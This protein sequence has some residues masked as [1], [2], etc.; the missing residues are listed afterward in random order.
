MKSIK[1]QYKIFVLIIAACLIIFTLSNLLIKKDPRVIVNLGDSI[2]GNI[3][4]AT[5]ISAIIANKTKATVY[6]G[7][8]GGCQMRQRSN[9][10]WDCFSMY[11]I[12]DA[13]S[14]GDW[15]E[16]EHIASSGVSGMP[17]YFSETV[18][19]LKKIDF[20][21][22][23]IITIA[24][25]L[26]DFTCEENNAPDNSENKYDLTT[27]AGALRYSI[28]KIS[29]AYPN[30]RIVILPAIWRVWFDDNTGEFID[31]SDEHI[32]NGYKLADF[33]KAIIDVAKEY[34]LPFIDTYNELEINKDNYSLFYQNG[35]G[36]HPVEYGRE[37]YALLITEKL[38]DI[39]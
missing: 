39:K 23:D 15:S 1:K 2:F 21:K 12:A 8:F 22:V 32:I 18:Q 29:E 13:I 35:D 10:H 34:D 16:Q 27:T 31:T 20:S 5:S 37:M 30:I 33:N 4:D 11:K 26:N 38:N 24:Y 36:A 3:R 7:G 14:S 19:T 25:G 9:T 17:D 28:E 6:N